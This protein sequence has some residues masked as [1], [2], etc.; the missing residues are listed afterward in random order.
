[1]PVLLLLKPVLLAAQPVQRAL[2]APVEASVLG[3]IGQRGRGGWTPGHAKGQGKFTFL[4][5]VFL[6]QSI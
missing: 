1:M 6:P 2:E 5:N 4:V 3:A